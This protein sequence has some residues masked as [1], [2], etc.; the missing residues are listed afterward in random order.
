MI[1]TRLITMGG[2]VFCD[3]TSCAQEFDVPVEHITYMLESDNY[4][5]CRL[6][7]EEETYSFL[8]TMTL[9]KVRDGATWLAGLNFC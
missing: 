4:P 6:L 2:W 5:G 1:D 7:T 8:Q 3:V 9:V